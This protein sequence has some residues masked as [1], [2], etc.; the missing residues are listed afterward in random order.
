[1]V[2][3]MFGICKLFFLSLLKELMRF[4]EAK[5]VKSSRHY[6]SNVCSGQNL[7]IDERIV[8]S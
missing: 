5:F 3:K 4:K 7:A 1:M 2:F 8:I 6:S